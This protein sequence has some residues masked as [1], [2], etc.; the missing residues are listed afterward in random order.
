[1]SPKYFFAS[2]AVDVPNPCNGNLS[3]VFDSDSERLTLKYLI[4]HPR[5][6]SFSSFQTSYSGIVKNEIS[7]FAFV[8]CEKKVNN[9]SSG[10]HVTRLTLTMGVMNSRRKLGTFRS[11]GKK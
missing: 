10:R 5:P 9:R 11:E 8:T 6:S 1:M 3:V 7:F 2:V 4:F